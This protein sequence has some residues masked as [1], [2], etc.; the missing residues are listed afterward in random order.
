METHLRLVS[1]VSGPKEVWRS[2][3]STDKIEPI[4]PGEVLMAKYFG[5]SAEFW[6]NMQSHYGLDR[7]EELAG[8]QIASIAPL[9]V[10]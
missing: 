7:A 4:H 6:I 1:T 10:A 3:T 8:E 2:L 9:R 5:A